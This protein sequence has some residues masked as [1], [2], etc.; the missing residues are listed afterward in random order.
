MGIKLLND[1]LTK[2]MQMNGT[3]KWCLGNVNMETPMY[4]NM[5]F[6]DTKFIN[7]NKDLVRTR[8]SSLRLL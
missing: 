8:E 3:S 2:A 5:K 7:S 1:E 4:E 6:S